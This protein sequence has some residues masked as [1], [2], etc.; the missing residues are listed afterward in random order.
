[1]SGSETGLVGSLAEVLPATAR[2]LGVELA[3]PAPP[4]W[5]LPDAARAVVV[6]IDGL[7]DLLLADRASYAPFL[8]SLRT[9]SS[10]PPGL[11]GSLVAGFPS[12]T[13]TSIASLGTGVPPGAHGMVGYQVL[14]PGTGRLLNE[15]SWE[16]G[17]DPRLWQPRRTVFEQVAAAGVDVAQTGPAFFAGSGLTE[18]ALRGARFLPART[19]D[20]RV[21]AVAAA[22]RASPRSLVYLYWGEVDKVGHVQGCGSYAWCDELAE[23]D[24]ALRSLAARLP[25]DCLLVVTADHGMVDVPLDRRV[26]LAGEDPLARKLAMGV[27]LTGGEPRAPMLYCESD[28]TQAVLA[29]WRAELMTDFDVLSRDEAVAA[30]WFGPVGELASSRIGDVVCAATGGRTVHDSRVQRTEL[31]ALVG[32][33][34]ARTDAEVRIPLLVRAPAGP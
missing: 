6:L 21:D 12:T 19:L 9:P 24:L 34:G 18:A 20:A 8:S 11:P 3:D 27:R 2:A 13:A 31:L 5:R 30:G 25:S 26:D 22:V 14:D 33:H 16:D 23:V 28:Q 7:G 29:R 4:T 17:P 1:M 15:L 32:M 10:R